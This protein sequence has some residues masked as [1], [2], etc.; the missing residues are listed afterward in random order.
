MD[1]K[2]S[3]L[4]FW[5]KNKSYLVWVVLLLIIVLIIMTAT[6]GLETTKQD[7]DSSQS[8]TLIKEEDVSS[9]NQEQTANVLNIV[10]AGKGEVVFIL[11]SKTNAIVREIQLHNPYKDSWVVVYDGYKSISDIPVEVFRAGLAAIAYDKIQ[12][13]TLDNFY[14]LEGVIVPDG[15]SITV[16]LDF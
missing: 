6:T 16:N 15:Q 5:Q 11:S 12:I 2:F 13:R 4:S 10:S 3:A 9:D 14:S 8:L 1:P 7:V